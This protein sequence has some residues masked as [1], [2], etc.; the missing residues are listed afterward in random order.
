M[1]LTLP[2]LLPQMATPRDANAP[3]LSKAEAARNAANAAAYCGTV[4]YN[5]KGEPIGADYGG[6]AR[7]VAN[8]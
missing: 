1:P 5:R 2:S 7:R 3:G 4:A 6:G 8:H